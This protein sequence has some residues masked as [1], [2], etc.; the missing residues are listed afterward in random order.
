MTSDNSVLTVSS[1]TRSQTCQQMLARTLS[2]NSAVSSLLT[3]PPH[4]APVPPP[5][6]ALTAGSVPTAVPPPSPAAVPPLAAC[7]SASAGV[8]LSGGFPRP[9]GAALPTGVPPPAGISSPVPPPA[10]IHPLGGGVPLPL[11]LSSSAGVVSM[12]HGGALRAGVARP[13]GIPMAIAVNSTL[14]PPR[15]MAGF[16]PS[17]PPP[18]FIPSMSCTAVTS[19]TETPA[20]P[21]CRAAEDMDLD[22]SGSSE[23]ELGEG[24]DEE[25][26]ICSRRTS[27]RPRDSVQQL[28]VS[29]DDGL[30]LRQPHAH[31]SQLHYMPVQSDDRFRMAVEQPHL[32]QMYGTSFP[33]SGSGNNF[34]ISSVPLDHKNPLPSTIASMAAL[35]GSG[36]V[37][38]Q[39]SLL[40]P[41]SMP[42]EMARAPGSVN[43]VNDNIL[44]GPADVD[45]RTS[46]Y[47]G[48][49][50][51]VGPPPLSA[52]MKMVPPPLPPLARQPTSS[53][54]FFGAVQPFTESSLLVVNDGCVGIGASELNSQV[55]QHGMLGP[56]PIC[57]VYPGS[58]GMSSH[59][60][61]SLSGVRNIQGPLPPVCSTAIVHGMVTNVVQGPCDVGP[62]FI[63][64]VPS[65]TFEPRPPSQQI[66]VQGNVNANA[67]MMYA[68][69]VR[70]QLPGS[71]QVLGSGQ[72]GSGNIELAGN[73]VTGS[74][75][76]V[77]AAN[78]RSLRGQ[79]DFDG[80][81][82]N[83]P[84]E[85]V[86]FNI[87]DEMPRIPAAAVA[88]CLRPAVNDTNQQC[89]GLAHPHAPLSAM[90]VEQKT[91]SSGPSERLLNALHSLAGMQTD[92]SQDQPSQG[93]R[94]NRTGITNPRFAEG[95][96]EGVNSGMQ[97]SAPGLNKSLF[98]P[99]ADVS[100]FGSPV[101]NLVPQ[102]NRTDGPQS[103]SLPAPPRLSTGQPRIPLSGN[104]CSFIQLFSEFFTV[105]MSCFCG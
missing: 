17:V 10:G 4:I 5:V 65:S 78:V 52:P 98:G 77:N 33:S 22:N 47:G 67:G 2:V 93:I 85:S 27:S 42:A 82:H 103:H 49:M 16:D 26:P 92:Q 45:L 58:V 14:P 12:L 74:R 60:P 53:Q 105:V 75:L 71:A 54:H 64:Q 38:G 89:V 94:S 80:V 43:L 90:P 15:F 86:A 55:T 68:V 30:Q 13:A 40:K 35:D 63:N 95:P 39:V 91:L 18:A 96:I 97:Q 56:R 66:L 73:F 29:R 62:R 72:L 100:G 32:N 44:T 61:P 57:A 88:S 50:V 6:G 23:E 7:I 20:N 24:F 11:V 70:S 99:Q 19:V 21:V 48:G 25:W 31:S 36:A 8:P 41:G 46:S 59:P 102:Q 104:I 87:H 76:P 101:R 79:T 69:A 34:A 1:E 9:L 3:Y 81:V 84:P 37:R 83:V 28:T 51:P